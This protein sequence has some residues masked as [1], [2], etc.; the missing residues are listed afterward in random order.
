MEALSER[1]EV[2][3]SP[4]TMAMLRKEAQS[5]GVSIAQLVREAI[6]ILIKEDRNLRINAAEALFRIEAP[7]AEWKEMKKEIEGAHQGDQDS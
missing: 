5:R 1:L 7:V 3:L 2:R 4:V 6:E